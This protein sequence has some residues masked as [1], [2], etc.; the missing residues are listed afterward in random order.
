MWY[1]VCR[2]ALLVLM[3]PGGALA[4]TGWHHKAWTQLTLASNELETVSTWAIPVTACVTNW[5][6]ATSSRVD[7][8]SF[9][10]DIQGATDGSTNPPAPGPMSLA[11]N[12]SWREAAE[13]GTNG[14][15]VTNAITFENLYYVQ[16]NLVYGV[17]EIRAFDL[18]RAVQE[19]HLALL[20]SGPADDTNAVTRY[21]LP[22]LYGNSRDTLLDIKAWIRT[23]LHQFADLGHSTGGT[24]NAYFSN[25]PTTW[26]WE[27]IQDFPW[28]SISSRW[29]RLYNTAVPTLSTQ[30]LYR[31]AGLPFDLQ[32][33]GV[34]GLVYGWQVSET[35]RYQV[36]NAVYT[37]TNAINGPLDT[38]PWAGLL[39]GGPGFYPIRTSRF[40]LVTSSTNQVT[41]VTVDVCGNSVTLI[42][43]NGQRFVQVCTNAGLAAGASSTNYGFWSARQMIT[44]LTAIVVPA[45]FSVTNYALGSTSAVIGMEDPTPVGCD[46]CKDD[47]VSLGYVDSESSTG[48]GSGLESA[49]HWVLL[50]RLAVNDACCYVVSN[51]TGSASGYQLSTLQNQRLNKVVGYRV[52]RQVD[53]YAM[54]WMPGDAVGTAG[55]Q[56]GLLAEAPG[57]LPIRQWATPNQGVAASRVHTVNLSAGQID[58][59]PVVAGQLPAAPELYHGELLHYVDA[60]GNLRTYYPTLPV[61]GR[62]LYPGSAVLWPNFRYR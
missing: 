2:L 45:G 31:L 19:M 24:F 38:T 56:R 40:V 21:G 41:N 43:T 8:V 60:G 3:L 54:W 36:A 15:T 29:M 61:H 58:A 37:I 23:Y 7:C 27:P 25:L 13:G 12:F 1:R 34:T 18:Y 4:W 57:P 9:L 51:G 11:W 32:A 55:G 17:P 42:G 47:A 53:Y 46:D 48:R 39:G 6:S 50:D 30:A 5:I 59:S 26:S 35:N 10:T 33:A 49:E 20:R 52:A 14:I 22:R 16:T 62:Q 28:M 44:N